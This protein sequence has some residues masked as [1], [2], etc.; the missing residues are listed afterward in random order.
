VVHATR[1]LAR[2]NSVEAIKLAQQYPDT[3]CMDAVITEWADNNPSAVAQWLE[4][5]PGPERPPNA[6]VR[7]A[8]QWSHFDLKAT[9]EWLA[10]VE[11]GEE[12]DRAMGIYAARLAQSD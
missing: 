11:P 7:L 6:V 12:R 1:L 5:Q 9:G 2:Q 3:N 4:A 10:R 8:E